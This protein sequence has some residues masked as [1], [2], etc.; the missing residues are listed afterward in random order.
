MEQNSSQS[1][2]VDQLV[3]IDKAE[4]KNVHCPG[5]RIPSTVQDDTIR[6]AKTIHIIAIH[7]W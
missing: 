5:L 4:W 1:Q 3:Q 6:N 7:G 2:N